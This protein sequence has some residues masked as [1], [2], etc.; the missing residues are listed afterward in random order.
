MYMRDNPIIARHMLSHPDNFADGVNFVFTTIQQ[1]LASTPNQMQDIRINGADSKYLFGSK[2]DGYM[3]VQDNKE[4]LHRKMCEFVET[5]DTIAALDMLTSIP[6]LGIVKAAFVAQLCGM[7]VACIDSHNC[8]RLGLARTALRLAKSVKPATKLKKIADYVALCKRTG[9]SQYWW[10]TW[11][12]YVAGN[13]ANKNLATG[14]AVSA[15]H[16]T[17]IMA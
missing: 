17:A 9:G 1:P 6:C 5:G 13:R 15:L 7:E 12:E 10:D 14:D 3:F 16:V 11:C 4:W 2:R 8:D